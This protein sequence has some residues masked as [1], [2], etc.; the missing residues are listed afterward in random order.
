ML[1]QLLQSGRQIRRKRRQTGDVDLAA[2][3]AEIHAFNAVGG[4]TIDDLIQSPAGTREGGESDFHGC[5]RVVMDKRST[6]NFQRLTLKE[7][8]D[9]PGRKVR[10][11]TE[12]K[13]RLPIDP[14]PSGLGYYGVSAN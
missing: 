14:W 13:R 6:F 3:P 1:F 2:K 11:L 4:G 9:S 10:D 5:F 12:K 8:L 7:I